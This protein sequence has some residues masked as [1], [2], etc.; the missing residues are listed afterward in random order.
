MIVTSHYHKAQKRQR[1]SAENFLIQ[2]SKNGLWSSLPSPLLPPT[3]RLYP[4]IHLCDNEGVSLG[5]TKII[6]RRTQVRLRFALPIHTNKYQRKVKILFNIFH[7]SI[8]L[9]YLYAE[10]ARYTSRQLSKFLGA[11]PALV[12]SLLLI[13]DITSGKLL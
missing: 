9:I 4:Y 8:A 13:D 1:M 6:R 3:C 7:F 10:K 11:Y 12:S 2:L 5:S